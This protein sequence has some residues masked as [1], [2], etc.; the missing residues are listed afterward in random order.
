MKLFK[1]KKDSET[2]KTSGPGW[3]SYI[4]APEDFDHVDWEKQNDR[5]TFHQTTREKFWQLFQYTFAHIK[6]KISGESHSEE[7]EFFDDE[8]FDDSDFIRTSVRGIEIAEEFE[9]ELQQFAERLLDS[10]SAEFE[11]LHQKIVFRQ[12]NYGRNQGFTLYTE[13]LDGSNGFEY[14]W[15]GNNGK[16][17]QKI[18]TVVEQLGF[19]CA[20]IELGTQ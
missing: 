3:S 9:S 14:G 19:A 7:N 5:Y 1:R 6:A 11:Y 12:K 4:E 16:R 8:E 17:A 18:D 15:L 2:E 20:Q 10:G 13:N